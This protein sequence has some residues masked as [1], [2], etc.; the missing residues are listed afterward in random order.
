MTA[1]KAKSPTPRPDA[2]RAAYL[3]AAAFL[4]LIEIAIALF[5]NGFLR[6]TVGDVLVVMLLYCIVRGAT[7]LASLPAAALCLAFACAVEAAQGFGLFAALGLHR[8]PLA[9]TVVG[10][11]FDPLDI[12]AYFAGTALAVGVDVWFL[13]RRAGT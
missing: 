2:P 3:V 13:R 12:G 1:G 4:F 7:P 11:T 9:K 5:A 10:A 6:H 8:E